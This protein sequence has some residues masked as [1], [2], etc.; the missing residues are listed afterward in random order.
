MTYADNSRPCEVPR[1]RAG[2]KSV[3]CARARVPAVSLSRSAVCGSM[4]CQMIESSGGQG[5]FADDVVLVTGAGSG[6]GYGTAMMFAAEGARLALVDIDG[7]AAT[8]VADEIAAAGGEACAI[9]ADVSDAASVRRM[10]EH[11]HAVFGGVDV[12]FN[13]AGIELYGDFLETSEE[14]WD[15]VLDVDLKS[16][17]LCS[18]AVAP[19]M[20][21][22]GG[23]AIVNTASVNSFKG[24]PTSVAYCAAKGGVLMFTRALSRAL[25]PHNIR[26]NCVCPGLTQ[27]AL[28][29]RW[30]QGVEDPQGTLDWA[31]GFQA[32]SRIGMPKDVGAAVLFLA[33]DDASWITGSALT[34]DGGGTA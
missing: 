16:V 20:I 9:E 3:D 28:A 31:I 25:G 34:V 32:I 24:D 23:G 17:F 15:R 21:A 13:N 11:A 27:T 7:D 8:R 2:P 5:R 30:L 18:K 14:A 12:L 4:T 1:A 19:Q 22:R 29:G 6:I 10:A 26:V 33:S